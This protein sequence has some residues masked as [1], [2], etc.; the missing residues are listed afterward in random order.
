MAGKDALEAKQ[1]MTEIDFSTP[2]ENDSYVCISDGR[3][4]SFQ[5]VNQ[6][7]LKRRDHITHLGIQFDMN[8][9]IDRVA[10]L[11]G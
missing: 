1:V 2:M 11:T 6:I 4:P 9:D 8:S 10:F 5:P 7:R 3:K